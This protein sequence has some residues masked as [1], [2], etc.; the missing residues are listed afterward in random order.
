MSIPPRKFVLGLTL[1]LGA[2]AL[3]GCGSLI[4][5][6]P[7]VAELGY[8]PDEIE[9]IAVGRDE[10]P[11]VAVRVNGNTARLLFDTGNTVGIVLHPRLA[12]RL[13]LRE[14]GRWA[15]HDPGSRDAGDFPKYS[16]RE[17]R[18]LGRAWRDLVVYGGDTGRGPGSIGAEPLVAGAF[19]L[20]APHRRL[21]V[22][23]R[24]LRGGAI[25]A[26]TLP[27]IRVPGRDG[28]P[29]TRVTIGGRDVLAE[30]DTGK[31]RTRVARSLA[32]SLGLAADAAAW[33]LDGLRFGSRAFDLA[34][35]EEGTFRGAPAL[36]APVELAIGADVLGRTV[37]TVDYRRGMVLVHR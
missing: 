9:A 25:A 31:S 28:L 15:G 21:A 5:E 26:D 18:T 17:V 19:T 6:P 16:A 1:A 27:L 33:R 29:V 14:T 30:L 35:V 12:K 10:M 32:R 36:P 8:R 24:P 34:A 20:D 23:A 2:V 37:V 22:T 4:L 11:Y 7:W 13:G 3:A